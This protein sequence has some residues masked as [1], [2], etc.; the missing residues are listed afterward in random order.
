MSRFVEF[1]ERGQL[2]GDEV[3]VLAER[4]LAPLTEAKVD[5]LLLGC[6]H[7][8]FLART[9]GEVMGPDVVLVSSADETAFEVSERHANCSF[10][11]TRWS[12]P[13][14]FCRAVMST[15]FVTLDQHCS[16]QTSSQQNTGSVEH[17]A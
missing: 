17:V 5:T 2:S 6:T 11:A 16:A 4:L 14:G 7:Y 9:I 12:E 3:M 1:V 10:F 15:R 8:P 13:V